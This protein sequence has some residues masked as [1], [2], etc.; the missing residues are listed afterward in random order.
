MIYNEKHYIVNY[1]LS[2]TNPTNNEGVDLR[3]P[4]G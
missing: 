2:N 4:E 3:A 1:R